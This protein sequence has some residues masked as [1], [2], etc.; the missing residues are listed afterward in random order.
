MQEPWEIQVGGKHYLEMAMQPFEFTLRNGW[1]GASH[2]ILK[3]V[4]RHK[5]KGG[6]EDVKKGRHI[7]EIRVKYAGPHLRPTRHAS[8]RVPIQ[9]YIAMNDIDGMESVALNALADWV[10]Y[11][12]LVALEVLR[13][14]LDYIIDNYPA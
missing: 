2:S 6:V 9:Q 4:S 12:D 1:D 13:R 5:A 10:N 11:D 3:Y 14:S 7:I 8:E